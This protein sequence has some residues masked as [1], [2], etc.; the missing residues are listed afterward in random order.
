MLFF[1]EAEVG[2][3]IYIYIYTLKNDY[4]QYYHFDF[5]FHV[6]KRSKCNLDMRTLLKNYMQ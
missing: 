5:K 4:L 6:V 1:I 3:Y 2:A